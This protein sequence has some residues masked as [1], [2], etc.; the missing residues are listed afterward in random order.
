MQSQ[1]KAIV[2][3]IDSRSVDKGN[4]TSSTYTKTWFEK[5]KT[6]TW[7]AALRIVQYV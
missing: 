6:Q 4:S 1:T 2:A 3:D 5:R 7:D